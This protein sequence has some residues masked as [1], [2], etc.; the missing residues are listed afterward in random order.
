M[1]LYQFNLHDAKITLDRR[2]TELQDLDA[3]RREAIMISRDILKGEDPATEFWS[4]SA[5]WKIWI[6]DEP[7][8]NGKTLLTLQER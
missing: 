2:G 6:T 1:A 5:P 3:V 7:S 8:G 4:G